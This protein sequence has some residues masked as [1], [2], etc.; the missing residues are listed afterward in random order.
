MPKEQ[1]Y[2]AAMRQLEDIAAKM[3]NGELDIDS[4]SE[5]LKTA[6]KL[7]KQ[8]KDKLTKTDED[9]RKILGAEN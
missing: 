2:E 5:Q 7:I 6:Q 4:L 1:K 9:I 8:C 3:E